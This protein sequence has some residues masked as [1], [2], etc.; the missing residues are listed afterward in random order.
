MLHNVQRYMTHKTTRH[1]FEE[2][3]HHVVDKN[4]P[5]ILRRPEFVSLPDDVKFTIVERIGRSYSKQ[6]GDTVASEGRVK[7]APLRLDDL[8]WKL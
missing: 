1:V 4:M 5:Q 6:S 8:E 7:S 2:A 3:L